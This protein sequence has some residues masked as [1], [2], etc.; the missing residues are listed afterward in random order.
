[1][2][3]FFTFKKYQELKNK[4]RI[5]WNMDPNGAYEGIVIFNNVIKLLQQVNTSLSVKE[6]I[7]WFYIENADLI[8]LTIGKLVSYLDHENK[9]LYNRKR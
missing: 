2:V 8:G 7:K 5:I 4:F 1:L 3:P 6:I 9:I